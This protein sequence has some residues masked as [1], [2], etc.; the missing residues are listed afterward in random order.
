MIKHLSSVIL[1]SWET[2]FLIKNIKKFKSLIYRMELYLII[3]WYRYILWNELLQCVRDFINNPT[4]ARC[5]TTC[6][7]LLV[8][9]VDCDLSLFILTKVSS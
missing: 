3:I 1:G 2:F 8:N 4:C 9:Q 5:Y 7:N 6:N